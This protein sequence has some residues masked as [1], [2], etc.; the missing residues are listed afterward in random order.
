[1]EKTFEKL[2]K[3]EITMITRKN[4]EH[5]QA[6]KKRR[7]TSATIIKYEKDEDKFNRMVKQVCKACYYFENDRC[8]AQIITRAYCSFCGEKMTFPTSDTDR[9]CTE[10]SKQNHLCKHCGGKMD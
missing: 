3:D 7:W 1:M 8:F 6:L 2:D 9:I 4:L 5:Y 10:C